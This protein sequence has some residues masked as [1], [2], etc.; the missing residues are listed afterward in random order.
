MKNILL[1]II[2]LLSF[3]NFLNAEI[4]DERI[5]QN[6]YSSCNADF[7]PK[8]GFTKNETHIYC[9][10]AAD[11]VMKSFTVKEMMLLESKI[12]QQSSEDDK[13]KIAL[14]NKKFE[15]IIIDCA[16]KILK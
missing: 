9:S 1:S 16:S 3:Q 11:E 12:A 10:C 15:G 14:A 7:D 2:F 5:R 4:K 8:L 13:I 6:F